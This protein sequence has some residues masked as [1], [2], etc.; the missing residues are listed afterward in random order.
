M[1][2]EV[3]LSEEEGGVFK[4]TA[5]VYPA[6]TATGRTEKEALGLIMEAM[7]KYMRAQ[8]KDAARPSRPAALR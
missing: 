4:A 5:V 8:A 1:Q 7:E 3:E 2:F 6:V